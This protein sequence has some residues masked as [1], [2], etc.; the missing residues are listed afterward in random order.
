M[1]LEYCLQLFRRKEK[2]DANADADKENDS[3]ES[4]AVDDKMNPQLHEPVL[5]N[6]EELRDVLEA[7]PF[8]LN[9]LVNKF[10]KVINEWHDETLANSVLMACHYSGRTTDLPQPTRESGVNQ[11]RQA[12]LS[13]LKRSRAALSNN[14]G[15]DPLDESRE[16][17]KECTGVAHAT[18]AKSSERRK[19]QRQDTSTNSPPTPNE[20]AADASTKAKSPARG[21]R[22][23]EENKVS[24]RLSFS[25]DE[26]EDKSERSP[27]R[28]KLSD[29]SPQRRL[30]PAGPKA[31]HNGTASYYNGPPPDEGV[32]DE[33][34]NVIRRTP[35]SVDETSCIIAALQRDENLVGNWVGIKN[36]YAHQLRNRST[37]QIKDKFRNLQKV[38]ALDFLKDPAPEQEQ[39]EDGVDEEIEDEDQTADC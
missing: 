26:S 36:M 16:I 34:G 5:K 8:D 31:V 13:G 14:H 25:E 4:G 10:E 37:I 39:E 7:K 21:P 28:A 18:R 2:S 27:Q 1:V 22:F 11:H 19:K 9:W 6:L 20:G 23:Y 29:V 32:F 35:W 15:E 38:H 12:N 30:S 17:A 3:L 24:S 33:L